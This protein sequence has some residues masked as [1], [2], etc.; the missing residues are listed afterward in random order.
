MS[1]QMGWLLVRN[2]NGEANSQVQR[3]IDFET[4]I[5]SLI[6]LETGV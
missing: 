2:A 3:P 6:F 5:H 4:L 1:L